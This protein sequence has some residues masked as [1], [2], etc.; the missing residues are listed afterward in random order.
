MFLNWLKGSFW[1][2]LP[3]RLLSHDASLAVK[4]KEYKYKNIHYRSNLAPGHR[5]LHASTH[6][7]VSSSES[8]L[9]FFLRCNFTSHTG[10][11]PLS[12]SYFCWNLHNFALNPE[13]L[14]L[15]A[16]SPHSMHIYNW[17]TSEV[18]LSQDGCHSHWPTDNT[19]NGTVVLK[20]LTLN[21]VWV[22]IHSLDSTLSAKYFMK[23][24]HFIV[25]SC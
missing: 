4:V 1:G 13:L 3:V 17:V 14:M 19:K 21:L 6:A 7:S 11:V 16:E 9:Q 22:V 15:H 23:R 18:N 10:C 5:K 25:N 20:V 8:L 12:Q 2:L 24:T